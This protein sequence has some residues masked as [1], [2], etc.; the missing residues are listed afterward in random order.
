MKRR[1]IVLLFLL[2]LLLPV[3]AFA[4]DLTVAV[5]AN[6]QYV[7]EELKQTFEKKTGVTVDGSIGSSGKFTAQI[8]NGAPFDVFLS[9][10][11]SYPQTLQKE[12]L[13]YNAPKVYGYG[14]LVIWTMRDVDL[15]KGFSVLA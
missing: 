8:E 3:Q 10:D 1:S 15:S 14:S 13:T 9:A 5:A 2:A 12:G 6:A 11:M 4:A 7:F